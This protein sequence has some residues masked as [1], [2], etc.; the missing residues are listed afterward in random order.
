MGSGTRVLEKKSGHFLAFGVLMI[1]LGLFAMMFPFVSSVA[2]NLFIGAML[3][4]GGVFQFGHA[5][6]TKGWSGFVLELV[7]SALYIGVGLYLVA[8]PLKGIFTLTVIVASLLVVQG[9]IKSV[10]AIRARASQGWGWVLFS[11]LV[12]V[13]LGLYIWSQLPVAALWT[14]GLFVGIDLSLLGWSLVMLSAAVKP[15]RVRRD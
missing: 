13:F 9:I 6:M 3:I 11:G 15:E 8:F 7:M 2:V 1:V 14:L 4:V 12:S 10:I 5:L